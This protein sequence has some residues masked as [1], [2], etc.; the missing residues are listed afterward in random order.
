MRHYIASG[1]TTGRSHLLAE[2]PNQDAFRLLEASWGSVAVVCD[3]CGSEPGSGL[4][5][6]L[7]AS[8]AA[9][10][11]ARQLGAGSPLDLCLLRAEILAGIS[12]VA[13][14]TGLGLRENF[15]FTI[16]GAVF[17][18]EKT[19]VFACGDGL[20]SLDGAVTVLGPF[21]D[22][23]PPYLAY[24]LLGGAADFALLHEG[25]AD[26]VLIGTDGAQ[27]VPLAPLL[28][29]GRYLKNPDLLRRRLKLA[30]PSDD[31]TVAVITRRD[32]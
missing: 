9:R 7:G 11:A 28:A 17:T 29:D 5:A 31:A 21:P 2:R 3:G 25:P 4:G 23:A 14:T 16:V 1:S 18:G 27:E 30:R 32:L 15:L 24:A 13:K 12:L 6:A 19:V 22:N 8:L 26:Q 10:S 20:F